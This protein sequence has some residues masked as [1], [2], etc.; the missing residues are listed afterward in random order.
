MTKHRAVIVLDIEVDNLH[1]V[2]SLQDKLRET[3]KSL[4]SPLDGVVFEG[5]QAEVII[6]ERR[7]KTGPIDRVVFRGTRGPN[8]KK[9]ETV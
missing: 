4:T 8:K 9:E 1:A 5:Y 2:L 7:G 3:A 6:A